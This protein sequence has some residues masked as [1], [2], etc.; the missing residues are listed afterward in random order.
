MCVCVC[1]CVQ[2]AMEIMAS[3]ASSAIRRKDEL[4]EELTASALMIKHA[5]H[6]MRK[7]SSHPRSIP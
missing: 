1:V 7:F 3:K 4:A 5:K 2:F 6:M